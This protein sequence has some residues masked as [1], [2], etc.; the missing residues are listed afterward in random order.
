M[1]VVTGGDFEKLLSHFKPAL[2]NLS[3]KI[4]SKQISLNLGRRMPN[5]S[6]FILQL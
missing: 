3:K 6:I 1:W 2:S 5:V 4:V